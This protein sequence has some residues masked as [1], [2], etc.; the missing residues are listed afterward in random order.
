MKSDPYAF[1]AAFFSLTTAE[2]IGTDP[3][4]RIALEVAYE[5]FENAGFSMERVKGSQAAV[6]IGASFSDYEAAIRRDVEYGPKYAGVGTT[7]EILSNRISHFFDLHGPSMTVETACSS[8]LV[9]VHLACQSIR[10]GEADMAVAGGVHCILNPDSTIMVANLSFLSSSGRSRSFDEAGDGYGRGEGCGMIVIKKLADAERDHDP[11]RAIIRGSG[12]NSDGWTQGIT[13]P[14][15]E[16]QLAL[17]RDVYNTFDLDMAS[18]QFVECHGTGTKVGDPAELKAIYGTIGKRKT[19]SRPLLV[20]SVKPNIGHLE[21]SSGVAGLIKGVLAMEHGLIPPQIHLEKLNTSIPFDQW[22]IVVPQKLTPWPVS[23][24][25]QMSVSSF[26]M[27]GTNAHVV[28]E[29]VNKRKGNSFSTKLM[30][31][32][33]G[34]VFDKKRL[35]TFSA[36][37]R[38]GVERVAKSLAKYLE[39]IGP[40][41]SNPQTLAN[42]AYTLSDRRSKLL[43][44]ATCVAEHGQELCEKLNTLKG[45][46]AAR[47]MGGPRI[48]FVFTGQGAQWPGMGVAL[49]KRTVFRAS[50]MDSAQFLKKCGCEWDVVEELERPSS[51]SLLAQP[52]ISQPICTILQMALV[53]ELKSWGV[54]PVSCVGHSSGEIGAAYAIGALSRQ[55]AITV[56]YFR[57]QASSIITKKRGDLNGGM[58]AVGLDRYEAEEWIA[59]ID[60]GRL[61]IACV[62]SPQ[63]IT[64]SGDLA[65]IDQ[66]LP[67]LEAEKIFA[68]KLKVEV[69]YH[70]HHMSEIVSEYVAA[71]SD[72][73][74]TIGTGQM[75][76]SVTGEAADFEELGAY[77]WARN[78]TSPVEFADA[79]L[80]LV[81]GGAPVNQ[82]RTANVVDILIELGPHSALG[83]P[84]QQILDA[85]E[86]KGVSYD[87]VLERGKDS[88]DTLLNLAADLVARGVPLN[89]PAVNDDLYCETLTSLPPYPWNHANTFHAE[90]RMGMETLMR[91]HPRK[92]LIGIPMP[93]MD[94]N[95]RM[96]RS[97]LSLEEEPW[98]RDHNGLSTVLFPASGMVCMVLEAAQQMADPGKTARAFK[99]RD[100]AFVAAMP[101]SEETPTEVIIHLRPHLCGTAASDPNSWW[102]F[103]IT[104]CKRGD[105]VLVDNCRGLVMIDYAVN[106]EQMELELAY[107][108]ERHIAEYKEVHQSCSYHV[109]K[110]TFY[111]LAKQSSWFFGPLFQSVDNMR[112][113]KDKYTYEVY[114]KEYGPSYSNNLVERPFLIH[115]AMLDAVFQI[116]DRRNDATD[117]QLGIDKAVVPV[118]VGEFEISCD[119]PADVGTGFKAYCTTKRQ[120]FHESEANVCWLDDKLSTVYL[121]IHKLC[122]AEVA[123]TPVEAGEKPQ[124]SNTSALCA[125]VHWDY[126]LDLLEPEDMANILKS[127]SSAEATAMMARIV[128]HSNP[129]T[130]VVELLPNADSSKVAVYGNVDAAA[131]PGQFL[132]AVNE[133]QAGAVSDIFYL[134][135][136]NRPIPSTVAAVD[137]IVVSPVSENMVGFEKLFEKVLLLAHPAT[138]VICT[139]NIETAGEILARNN[140]VSKLS[141]SMYS[142]R[143]ESTANGIQGRPEIIII[144]PSNPHD[145]GTKLAI[146]LEVALTAREYQVQMAS[147]E[148][149]TVASTQ[150]K[151]IISLLEI[152]G[153]FLENLSEADFFAL[154]GIILNAE[155]LIWLTYGVDPIHSLVDGLSRVVRE[156]VAGTHFDVLHLSQ[157]TGVEKSA[158]LVGRI[159]DAHSKDSEWRDSNGMLKVGR[160]GIDQK[161]NAGVD[162]HLNDFESVMPLREHTGPLRLTVGKPGLLDTLHFIPDDRWL[163]EPLGELEVEIEVKASGL[164]FRDI[165]I[166]M[167]VMNG[168]FLGFEV[169]GLVKS[170]G[171]M[172]TR[173]KVGD[174]VAAFASGAHA[175]LVRTKEFVCAKISDDL[176]YETAAAVSVVHATAYHAFVNLA[177]LRRGQSV[178]IHAAG[179]GVG[180]A[181]I[182]MAKHLGLLIY[183][184]V[185]STEKRRL[186][187]GKYDMNPDHI[188]SSRDTSFVLGIKRVTNNRGVDCILNSL[189]GELLRQ[190]WYCLAAFGTFI[191]L[192]LRDVIGNTRLDMKPFMQNTTFTLFDLVTVTEKMPNQAEDVFATVH[193]LVRRGIL[194]AP[195]NLTTYQPGDAESAFRFMQSGRHLGKLVLTM[196]DK[197]EVPV[198]HKA[199][200]SLQLDSKATYLLIGGLGGLGRSLA[201]LF[202]DSGACN[203]AFV[204]RS[205]G[206]SDEAKKAIAQLQTR[207]GVSV[208]AYRADVSDRSSFLQ[209][210]T[211]CDAELPPIKGVVQMA[212]VLKDAVFE[213]MTFT[214]W[215]ASLRPKVHGTRNLHEYFSSER[216]LDFM[217]F[218]SS[219]AGVVGNPGQANYAAGNT[220]QDELAQYRCSQGLKAVSLDLG[221]MRDVGVVAET[222]AKGFLAVWEKAIGLREPVFHAVMRFVINQQTRPAADP[223]P[224]QIGM[225]LPTADIMA[226]NGI[227]R[228]QIFDDPRMARL[229]L[230]AV[231]GDDAGGNK[232]SSDSIES[233]LGKVDCI[234][235]ATDIMSEALVQKMA[236]MLQMETFD[237]DPRRPLSAYGLDSLVAIEV[238]NWILRET[239]VN[240]PLLDILAAIPM[241]KL[242]AKIA[243]MHAVH[244]A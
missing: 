175:T 86:I 196:D 202:V 179:G 181:A 201:R 6:C 85:A 100:L 89:I 13:L 72:I 102:E 225:G 75:I 67:M 141:P 59:K 242:A 95:E 33:N 136:A 5:A 241:E 57:G 167:G 191:E 233:R 108:K 49:L 107:V 30:G 223:F 83:G 134:D 104:S 11:I 79:L 39:D 163:D 9:A 243:Q 207:P 120:E 147:W 91:K 135:E 19:P 96:W 182:Q 41:S 230:A 124:K 187:I 54:S 93:M 193:D 98:I 52:H 220:Y 56:A 111:E 169:S 209:A 184:T 130:T 97:F 131:F 183:A 42:L 37:D 170:T 205:G 77:Y 217:I 99:L 32:T 132:Y 188:F 106:S 238:R 2:A 1:D 88:T 235:G 31:K 214:D 219:I 127:A 161:L 148:E 208:K 174:R 204:S 74:P 226:Q 237:V 216:P 152:E 103:T 140:F 58:V 222:G 228:P 129:A 144:L 224:A 55:D 90:S 186:L 18:T 194:T 126:A 232:G 227:P 168:G 73:E 4:Q 229:A 213:K 239:K 29:G 20:G 137:L 68:R 45:D 113:G 46:D 138:T 218:F 40:A 51:E 23:K 189:S 14:N 244:K 47:A 114:A 12:T 206:S 122:R 133:T 197:C 221:I 177:K 112:L 142:Q 123:F 61:N 84:I 236:D 145:L 128:L 76:S 119:I 53:D 35:Y 22:N 158:R 7:Q 15:S 192:G 180:Q 125:S 17:I 110:S 25:K 151:I 66:L 27:G 200:H 160:I 166:S 139:A 69:A 60:T 43:W 210:M 10:S 156:E 195:Y 115:P 143:I 159:L 234:D 146:Q 172:V 94:E 240:I 173:V 105:Q 199:S 78:L 38:A 155:H 198:L 80:E 153:S 211:E 64:I 48:G 8:S 164:N 212:M 28:L 121:S 215:T 178:L 65:A 116:P 50:I 117:Q 171:R 190:S 71:I 62:N 36:S 203:L 3:R 109:A 26:G 157:D 165:M 16:A 231:T 24:V 21:P 82:K 154:K 81:T 92:S 44:M 101:M 150:G 149:G 70:S 162:F 118:F 63:S 34:L 176:S 87:C 185:S